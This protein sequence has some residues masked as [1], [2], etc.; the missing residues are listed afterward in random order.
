MTYTTLKRGWR[1]LFSW[2]EKRPNIFFFSSRSQR[3]W[4]AA[5]IFFFRTF[6][7]TIP[8]SNASPLK[9]GIWAIDFFLEKGLPSFS[10]CRLTGCY[11]KQRPDTHP[12]TPHI[13][14]KNTWYWRTDI[15]GFHIKWCKYF[16]SN[17]RIA[18]NRR[19]S[20]WAVSVSHLTVCLFFFFF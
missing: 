8:W 17:Q 4:V 9:E 1:A 13:Q 7:S 12:G 11:G 18:I 15:A 5:R 3:G 6:F 10:F 2:Q 19:I 20:N 14:Q 16:L